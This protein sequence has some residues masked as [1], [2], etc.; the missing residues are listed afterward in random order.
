MSLFLV[1]WKLW[2]FSGKRRR[3]QITL[4][5]INRGCKYFFSPFFSCLTFQMTFF[6][7][8]EDVPSRHNCM[9]KKFENF[10]HALLHSWW[11]G[12]FSACMSGKLRT[13][14]L[15]ASLSL[16]TCRARIF[17]GKKNLGTWICVTTWKQQQKSHVS[18]DSFSLC[19]HPFKFSYIKE[20]KNCAW[21]D[22]NLGKSAWF[23]LARKVQQESSYWATTKL[24]RL[25]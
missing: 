25:T 17:P 2:P 12:H 21:N 23:L 13:F 5:V 22:D 14:G 18:F 3:L 10:L 16:I 20:M 8:Q 15:E 24:N 9:P 6:S 11:E 4:I 7:F 1:W 19:T